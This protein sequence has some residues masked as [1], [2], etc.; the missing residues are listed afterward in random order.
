MD[1]ASKA[2]LKQNIFQ[3]LLEKFKADSETKFFKEKTYLMLGK[4]GIERMRSFGQS[5][6]RLTDY[7][8]D[9]HEREIIMILKDACNDYVQALT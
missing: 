5:L 4:S 7:L 3:T 9:T 8:V 1:D 2:W 6:A